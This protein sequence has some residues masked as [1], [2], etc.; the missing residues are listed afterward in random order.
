MLSLVL[1]VLSLSNND[2]QEDMSLQ[3]SSFPISR[4]TYFALN[5]KCCMLSR[6]TV[7]ANFIATSIM[8]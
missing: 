2:P 7:N 1:I 4:Q 3:P 8:P 6:N 5:H